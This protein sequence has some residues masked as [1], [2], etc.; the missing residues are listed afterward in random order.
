MNEPYYSKPFF[1][2][3]FLIL[4]GLINSACGEDRRK[5]YYEETKVDRW[6]E[7]TMR[8]HY[9][10]YD[11]MPSSKK[12]N[13]FSPPEKFFN[14]L[15]FHNKDGKDGDGKIGRPYSYIE[16]LLES[17]VQTRSIHN[18]NNSYGFEFATYTDNTLRILYVVDDSPASEAGLERGDWILSINENEITQ[19]EIDLLF[20]GGD[21]LKLE[22]GRFNEED[23]EIKPT[24]TVTLPP[25]RPIEDN[26]IYTHKILSVDNHNIGYIVYNHFT[27]HKVEANEDN[28]YD[29][30]L[31]ELS[32]R[33]KTAGIKDFV[34]DLRYNNGG[35]LS[36][37]SL[38][39]EI[40]APAS[41]KGDIMYYL[42]YNDQFKENWSGYHFDQYYLGDGVNLDLKTLYVLVSN[43]TASA[44]ELII[45]C[46]APYMKVVL[47]G[48]QTEGKNVGSTVFTHEDGEWAIHPIIFKIYNAKEESNYSNGFTPDIPFNDLELANDLFELGD[49]NE[50]LLRIA[51][52]EITGRPV[53]RPEPGRSRSQNHSA[54]PL[55]LSIDSKATPVLMQ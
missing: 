43:A 13:F 16:N 12:L 24:K 7:E 39:C 48:T 3:P 42:E 4:V 53:I 6:I 47:I 5:E 36:S 21:A 29:D 10:W 44:S 26:P 38:L 1:L 30:Q 46:L 23:K 50:T 54:R 22:L 25:S 8:K 20:N 52:G 18:T 17:G 19:T 40:L 33:F 32:H 49:P 41:A 55:K 34:L 9:Y 37:A 2:L 51:I 27:P 31:R 45:N 28:V 35:Y 15:L 14:E 11:K